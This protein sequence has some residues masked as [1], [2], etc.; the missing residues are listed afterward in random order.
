[1]IFT[2]FFFFLRYVVSGSNAIF[3]S[4]PDFVFFGLQ[5][6]F[7]QVLMHLGPDKYEICFA[8]ESAT[9]DGT[10]VV[11]RSSLRHRVAAAEASPVTRALRPTDPD[12]MKRAQ[13][14]SKAH[15][16]V[17]LFRRSLV[18]AKLAAGVENQVVGA[19]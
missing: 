12:W 18:D 10:L 14:A 11:V 9:G 1:M 19:S 16:E 15:K 7:Y 5:Y 8:S 2:H 6:L 3:P 13:H 17:F 4:P